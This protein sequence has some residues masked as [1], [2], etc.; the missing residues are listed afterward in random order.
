MSVIIDK[1]VDAKMR[2]GTVLRADIYRPAADGKYPVLLQRTPYNKEF[3]PFTWP[4]L[5]P[6][7]AAEAG[8]VVAIQ[9]VRGRW[10]SDGE[11][12]LYRDEFAD[13][14]DSVAWA[15]ELPYSDGS[16]AMYGISYMGGSSWNAA[17]TAPP[18]LKA[19]A[20]ATAP[21]SAQHYLRDG[22]FG[23]GLLLA[24]AVAGVGPSELIRTKLGSPEFFSEFLAMIDDIDDLNSLCRHLP[25]KDLPQIQQGPVSFVK[26]IFE[27]ATADEFTRSMFIED[28]HSQV[29]TPALIIAGWHDLLLKDDL[30]HF[31]NMRDT[32]ATE[33]ARSKTRIV[34][35]PWSHATFLNLVGER[36]YGMRSSGFLLDL[37]GDLTTLLLKWFDQRL[38]DVPTGI[39]QEPRVKY[40][41]QGINRWKTSDEWPP[42]GATATPF[43]LHGGGTLSADPPAPNAEP[44]EYTFDPNDP[45]P[46]RGG[47]ILMHASYLRGPAEQSLLLERDDVLVFTSQPME[48]DTEVTGEVK[49]ILHAATDGSDTDWAV[50]LCEVLPDGR[51]YDVCDGIL[52]A[53]YRDGWH[54]RQPVEP[55]AV[56]R[57]EIDM[58]ATSIVFRAGHRMR[59]LVTS[60]DFPRYDRNPNTGELGVDAS[61]LRVAQQKIFVDSEKASHLLLPVMEAN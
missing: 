26:E 27:H 34:I 31:A 14:H 32:A 11:F 7:R 19:I 46:T 1:N 2:D 58:W 40:F 54:T 39:D 52:R 51:T 22:T 16:V 20:P 30:T 9:D 41:V 15:S 28:R 48:K 61:T 24:W 60:S 59:V 4:L 56:V 57:Y 55:G 17:S 37:Q 45:V 47:K 3:W 29:T 8:Y 43:Y 49:A 18:A 10:A 25:L 36:E 44:I 6:T 53:S 12:F 42:P 21:I 13:G 33:E 35:G 5:D 38:K 23:I 50:K